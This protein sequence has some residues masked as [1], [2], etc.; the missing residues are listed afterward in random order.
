M[1]NVQSMMAKT[2]AEYPEGIL[3]EPKPETMI[4]DVPESEGVE[5]PTPE[6]TV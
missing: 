3:E 4:L 2:L 5:E 1:A 6:V